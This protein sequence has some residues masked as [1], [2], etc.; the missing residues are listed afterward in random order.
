MDFSSIPRPHFVKA[1]VWTLILC[2]AIV[3]LA[4]ALARATLNLNAAL[5]DKP[6][7]ALYVL[8]PTI[9]HAEL[10]RERLT[11]RDYLVTSPKGH[12][13]IKIRKEDGLWA[14]TDRELLHE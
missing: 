4:A 12:E 8:D 10:L 3:S 9:T 2:I 6:D 1:T 7:L 13:L 14:M 5:I 11:Q